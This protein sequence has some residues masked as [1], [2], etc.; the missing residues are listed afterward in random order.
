[1]KGLGYL[2]AAFALS[3]CGTT[4]QDLG[5]DL[6]GS[7]AGS[8][9]GT[10]QPGQLF[11]GGNVTCLKRADG[12]VKC[13]GQN[14]L[15]QLSVAS[16]E[17][18]DGTPCAHQPRTTSNLTKANVIALGH[19]FGCAIQADGATQCWGENSLGQLGRGTSDADSHQDPFNVELTRAKALVAG[20]QHACALTE[21]GDVLC[22]GLG[23]SGQLGLDPADLTTCVVPEPSRGAPGVPETDTAACALEPTLVP[24]F[25]G[26][27][28]LAL[29][30]AH[31]CARFDDG[32]VLCV[33][34]GASG[35]L[36]GG[37][38]PQASFEPVEAF[39]KDVSGLAAG[40]RHNCAIVDAG[41]RV[42]C[43]G[44]N[45]AGQLGVGRTTQEQCGSGPCLSTPT[46]LGD[47]PSTRELALGQSF[48]CALLADGKARCWGSDQRGQL[49][50]SS[51]AIESCSLPSGETLACSP[52][53]LQDA[54]DLVDAI[55]LRA[56]AEHA[57]ATVRNEVRCWG[58][59]AN[60]QTS[61]HDDRTFPGT[62]YGLN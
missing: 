62:V 26:A 38:R 30:D 46:L 14:D 33:G 2:L 16:E 5:G 10:F 17:T 59:A 13:W 34:R 27:V 52:R 21:T 60:G 55:E 39:A 6:P 36:G 31:S 28:Q 29:G 45:E 35:E 18:C 49:G 51:A 9:G 11:A 8:G 22:W 40:G 61:D 57:C 24:A 44:A 12:V 56:G 25:R 15:G 58:S 4:T 50:N 32:R 3:A 42:R 1:M 20:A 41:R 7:S 48:S 23:E 37:D 43:W 47:L 53:P 19:R 54:Y